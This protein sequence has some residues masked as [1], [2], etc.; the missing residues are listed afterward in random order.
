[1]IRLR[2]IKLIL[3][4]MLILP[5]GLATV[6]CS[7]LYADDPNRTQTDPLATVD[8][9]TAEIN[10]EEL[11][12]RIQTAIQNEEIT[13]DQVDRTISLLK[14]EFAGHDKNSAKLE[15]LKAEIATAVESGEITQEEADAK[16]AGLE[17]GKKKSKK[18][19]GKRHHHKKPMMDI[20][21]IKAEIATAVESGEITQEEADAK[22]TD[23]ESKRKALQDKMAAK[24]ESIKAE[25]AAA[26]ESGEITQEE[27]DAK[28]AGLEQGK[29]K[30]KK[31]HGKR[32][33]HKKPMMDIEEIKAKISAAVESG[34]ITQE[35]ASNKLLHLERQ[36]KKVTY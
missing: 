31:C 10:I 27:A 25:I 18:W 9:I 32:H 1:M 14:E 26:V 3:A 12:A 4:G 7:P 34:E 35:E 30:G 24:L 17:E 2:N 28:L 20:E 36:P 13:Q 33:Q 15:S 5:M 19:H 22:L 21:E 11:E 8:S 6:A 23:I 29:E 16:L